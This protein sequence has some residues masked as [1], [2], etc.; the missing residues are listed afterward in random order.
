M[1]TTL[2]KAFF[3]I[4]MVFLW[5][6]AAA[7]ADE[8]DGQA[9]MPGPTVVHMAKYPITVG[10]GEFELLTIIMDFPAGAGVTNHKHGGHVLVTVLSGDMTL[11]EKGGERIVKTGES[12]TEK[13]GDIHAVVNAGAETA[14]VAVSI[15][16]PKGGE[17]TTMVK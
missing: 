7:A 13:P 9:A 5:V 11:R 10:K 14:R 1:M 4:L 6:S 3:A 8:K 16:I 15:L 12:W 17:V 2:K